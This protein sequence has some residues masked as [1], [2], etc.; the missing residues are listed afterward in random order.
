MDIKKIYISGKITGLPVREAI[1][2]FRSAAEKIRRFGFEPVSPFD[3][4]LP[5]EAD[6]AEHIGKDISLL[7]RC[8]EKSEGARIE[9]C[10][11]LHRRMPVFMNVRPKLGFF[12]VQTFEDYDKEKV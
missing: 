6:W 7:L 10:I 1:A 9:L 4:G 8:D 2:K 12:S 5:L 11:A 3:N